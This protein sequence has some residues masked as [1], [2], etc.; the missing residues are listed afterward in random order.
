MSNKIK[1]L[2]VATILLVVAAFGIYTI[3]QK[4]PNEE[5]KKLS[6]KQ[7]IEEAIKDNFER[8]KD[9]ELG[10]PPTE[11]LAIAIEET[12]EMQKEFALQKND[13]ANARFR[14][15][16]PKNIGGRT[17]TILI[18]KNDPSGRTIFVGGVTG[19]L[20][21]S[22]DISAA[23]PRWKKVNDYLENLSV[24]ALAQD[25][26]DPQIMYMGTGEGY[27]DIASG[28]GIFRSFDGGENWDL[29][30]STTDGNFRYTRSLLVHPSGDVYVGT[31]TGLYRSQ[32]Q[33]ES[34]ERLTVTGA[35]PNFYDL[36]YIESNE[37]IY[38]SATNSVHRS[39]T[40]DSRDWEDL[41]RTGTG[42]PKNLSRTELTVSPTVPEIMYIIGSIGGSA[43]DVFST[44]NGGTSWL[45]MGKVAGSPDF[46]NGQAWY[47]L[48]IQVDPFN[49][50]HIIAGG[51]PIF[52]SLNGGA[53]WNGFAFNM[54]VDHHITLFDPDRQGVIYFGND[55][56][57]YRS[58]NGSAP[59]LQNRNLDYN[60]TQFY[61]S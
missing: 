10:Y 34:W 44:R 2:S 35:L 37:Y 5:I 46:T 8:T 24:G 27:G 14:E 15:R 31:A 23:Q 53:S 45:N 3:R 57:I 19:G 54:H 9:L 20:W 16:G 38:A 21:K 6:K 4:T 55:G 32:N 30:P 36:L 47:D 33:G 43:S 1:G 11:R 51:V 12:R 50:Q 22:D 28:V 49:P 25:A 29:L 58:T 7:R 41:S 18:D 60:V 42:F 56:G 39:K 48:E 17:R 61:I 59:Q 52:R 40:G 26:N 13:L